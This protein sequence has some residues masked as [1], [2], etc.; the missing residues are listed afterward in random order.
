MLDIV[1]WPLFVTFAAAALAAIYKAVEALHGKK[2]SDEECTRLRAQLEALNNPADKSAIDVQARSMVETKKP[3]QLS[4]EILHEQRLDQIG[5]KILSLIAQNE[6]LHDAEIAK[7]AGASKQ[8]ITL[9]LQ[10]LKTKNLVRSSFGLDEN[11][12]QVDTWFIEQLGRKYL[13]QHGLL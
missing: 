9:H 11:S 4:N 5:E 6:R 13:L 3:P 10:D 12:Y 1:F 8:L 7:L 2:L